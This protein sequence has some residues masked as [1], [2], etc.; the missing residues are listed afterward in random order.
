MKGLRRKVFKS[1]ANV[2]P[3]VRIDL[4]Y[5]GIATKPSDVT[6]TLFVRVRIDLIYE[7]IATP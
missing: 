3:S 7:G 1:L 5:E 2:S 6:L 4:I